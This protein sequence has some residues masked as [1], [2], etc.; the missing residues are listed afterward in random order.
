MALTAVI[1]MSALVV[2]T[3]G[4]AGAA[5]DGVPDTTAY[6]PVHPCTAHDTSREG[7]RF[8]PGEVRTVPV[9]Q[10]CS[11]GADARAVAAL[12]LVG[13]TGPTAGYVSL[14]PADAPWP[15]TSVVNWSGAGELR[16]TTALVAVSS[17]GELSI[18]A[19]GGAHL[20]VI[21]I[22]VF[23]PVRE[24][25][26][27]RIVTVPSERILDTRVS[28]VA[29]DASSPVTLPLPRELPPDASAVI[30]NVTAVGSTSGGDVRI[31]PE[32]VGASV[33]AILTTD[34][35]GQTRAS[36]TIVRLPDSELVVRSTTGGHV[37]V[38]LVGYVTGPASPISADGLYVPVVPE[39]VH[40]TRGAERIHPG[41]SQ[42]IAV[43][44]GGV[45]R[46]AAIVA[47]VTAA[48]PRAAGFVSMFP[49]GGTLPSTSSLN[50]HADD[51]AVATS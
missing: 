16:V 24:S 44:P 43:L 20:A 14:W 5:G 15:G 3:G 17:A 23:E 11:L 9:V 13:D 46:A 45:E 36:G 51:G 48:D 41:G 33:P 22:G 35:P 2:P 12:V 31:G 42:Q 1:A 37:L 25:A 10:R 7:G 49:A 26:A 21:V 6:R 4:F 39:R 8:S 47:T 19:A 32:R 30:V 40:D 18:T 28:G 34:A 38:D 50:L 29:P 27:G